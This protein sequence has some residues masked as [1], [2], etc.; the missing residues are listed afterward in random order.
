MRIAITYPPIKKYDLYPLLTQNRHLR[1][2]SSSEVRIF[3]LVAASAAT[4]LSKAGHEVL[5]LDGINERLTWEQYMEIVRKFNP[6]LIA[7]ETKAP[8]V[9]LHWK[10]IDEL[11]EINNNIITALFG[12]HVSF[13][14]EESIQESKVD[15]VITGGD[16]DAVLSGLVEYLGGNKELPKGIYYRKNNKIVN[17]GPVEF[18]SDL[19][20]VPFIDREL[21]KWHLYGEA[22]LYKPVAYILSGRGCGVNKEKTGNCTF[23][24]W[25]HSLWK[26]GSRLRSPENV[27]AEI[28][29][30]V[31]KFRA[32]EVF[33]D[34][35]SGAIWNKEWIE[36]FYDEMKKQ[37]LI[38]KVYISSNARANSLDDD[39]CRILKKTGFRL[40]KVGLES[41]NN[42]TLKKI[43]KNETIEEII[44]G[45][46]SAKDSGLV[47]ML[48]T[49]V[50]YPWES[51]EDVKRT[52]KVSKELTLYKTHCGDSLQSS[53]ILPYPGTILHKQAVSNNWF[54]YDYKDYSIYDMSKPVLKADI[55]SQKW[56]K[57]LW[58]IHYSPRFLLRTLFT[59][60]SWHDIYLLYR[61]VKSL[62]GHEKDFSNTK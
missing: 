27:V 47:V 12:D 23:C 15:Y 56:C 3:P 29:I 5:F 13:F 35:E 36:K 48:T 18:I 60:R 9:H 30:L 31:D 42:E 43:S 19:D 4:I 14:P 51:E 10:F 53:V 7:M 54:L 17:S 62:F 32:V 34:N 26:C 6:E 25:Q 57:K 40:L 28:R 45:V 21:T 39:I 24:I 16:Y 1:F 50:G 20:S 2:S 22:Y 41:G 61:G 52:Y 46:K 55:D 8:V 58:Q 11:K 33:D 59:I 37:D 38:G 44:K 49:M